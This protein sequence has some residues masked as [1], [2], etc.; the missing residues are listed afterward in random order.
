MAIRDAVTA[1][2][3]AVLTPAHRSTI[4]AAMAHTLPRTPAAVVFDFDGTIADTMAVI[5]EC[6]RAMYAALGDP[7]PT[8][9]EIS[10]TIGVPLETAIRM[11]SG[12][13]DGMLSRA[14]DA[15]RD[16]M[17]RLDL[18]LVQSF[19]GMPGV[20]RACAAAGMPVAVAS[21]RSHQSL[22]PMLSALGLYETMAMVIDHTDAGHEK[23]HPA[24]LTL[25][26][27]SLGVDASLLVMVGD[28]TFD[29]EMGHAAGAM[30]IGVT[31]GSH[32]RTSI[33]RA[34]PTVIADSPPQILAALGLTPAANPGAPPGREQA[35]RTRHVSDR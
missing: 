11:Q 35:L 19:D 28:T 27:E 21:S 22:D 2:A 16:A 12:Y 9:R 33:E 6:Y 8:D 14:V 32:E 7:C 24:M 15:Y 29:V 20:I 34:N 1:Y 26:A 31:W 25:I 17:R 10:A 18:S 4:F 5:I 3:G 13:A 30:T 23:P